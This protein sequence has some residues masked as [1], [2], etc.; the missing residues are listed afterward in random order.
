MKERTKS[1]RAAQFIESDRWLQFVSSVSTGLQIGVHLFNPYDDFHMQVPGF[2]AHCK[3]PYSAYSA[4]DRDRI[5]GEVIG[6][7]PVPITLFDDKVAVALRLSEDIIV[8]FSQCACLPQASKLQL[9]EKARIA[10]GI[11]SSFLMTLQENFQD[12]RRAVELSTLRKMNH[13]MLSL[14]RGDETAVNR[15]L[16]L[17][18]SAVIVL[19]DAQG[20]WLEIKSPTHNTMISKGEYELELHSYA[21][22]LER[23]PFECAAA[24]G[25][26]GVVSPVDREQAQQLLQLMAHECAIILEVEYL[27]KMVQ[28][29]FS[30]VLDSIHSAVLIVDKRYTISYVNSA[31]QNLLGGLNPVGRQAHE[32]PGPWLKPLL[33][34]E[35]FPVTGYM[36]PFFVTQDECRWL[37]WQLCA[38]REEDKHM[39]WVILVDDRTDFHRWQEA[40]R[41]SERFATTAAMVEKLAHEMRN[42][43]MAVSGLLQLLRV[44]QEP[45]KIRNYADLIRVEID[46]MT[47]LLND[48]FLL[49]T[50]A[51]IASKPLDLQAWL[52]DVHALLQG[53]VSGTGIDIVVDSQPCTPIWGDPE[54]LCKAIINIVR[55]AVSSTI[56]PKPITIQLREEPEYLALSV[57][58]GGSG[59]S[60]EVKDSLFLPFVTTR[61]RSTG[62]GLT[63]VQSVVH[64]HGG[65]ISAANLPEG[66]AVFTICLPKCNTELN[67]EIDIDIIVLG[68]EAGRSLEDT[69][70]LSGF[71]VIGLA[72]KETFAFLSRHSHPKVV[73]MN[74]Y[75]QSLINED[76]R[77]SK[78]WPDAYRLNLD[79]LNIMADESTTPEFNCAHLILKLRQ[80][81]A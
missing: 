20:A 37:D 17:V 10:G 28:K 74:T 15:V 18:L 66:G 61:E 19:L 38:L 5:G 58:D 50:P 32:I 64:N 54:Q 13:L 46:R 63:I 75:W 39:G 68:D 26:L 8:I 40:S 23:Q 34:T 78:F 22:R 80:L 65:K 9:I 29:R 35:S 41:K 11:L 51:S 67:G 60:P 4:F 55:N 30:M 6:S 56:E 42:P 77:F 2:C 31:A 24:S 69:L 33:S 53:E 62:L 48:F 57:K 72:D 79:E 45:G 59:I 21:P 27:F 49:G 73:V 14:F 1:A 12:S 47:G 52:N 43:L 44:K 3:T 16:D 70:R 36:E 76:K 25:E 7:Q 71:S 81:L